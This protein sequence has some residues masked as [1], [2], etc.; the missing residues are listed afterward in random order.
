MRTYNIR[1]LWRS[2]IGLDRV[3]DLVDAARTAF[4]A[5]MSTVAGVGTV[6]FVGLAVLVAVAFRHVPATSEA[7]PAEEVDFVPANASSS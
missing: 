4:T 1:P 2:T 7:A 5:G 3:F 6:V